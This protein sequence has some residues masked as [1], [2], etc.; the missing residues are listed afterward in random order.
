MSV[1]Q[2]AAAAAGPAGLLPLL[3][4]HLPDAERAALRSCCRA[5]LQM[6][7]PLITS[8]KNL[9]LG[10][11]VSW[12]TDDASGFSEDVAAWCAQQVDEQ[13]AVKAWLRRLPALDSV[14][15]H[16]ASGGNS[17]LLQ[18]LEQGCLPTSLTSL[19]LSNV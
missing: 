19:G 9:A 12:G 1:L 3:W 15:A 6:S 10:R 16:A 18:L 17:Q 7:R 4:Q 8:V 11:S 5:L 2:A 14:D 13:E